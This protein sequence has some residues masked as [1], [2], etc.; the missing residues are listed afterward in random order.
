MDC[1]TKKKKKKSWGSCYWALNQF[2]LRRGIL[3]IAAAPSTN[4]PSKSQLTVNNLFGLGW[5]SLFA[6][7][8]SLD[9]PLK[10]DDDSTKQ[11]DGG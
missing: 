5:E 4:T 6:L 7:A 11:L 2:N 1:G 9:R 10:R 8:Q 3:C